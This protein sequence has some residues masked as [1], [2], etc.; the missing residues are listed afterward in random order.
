L[1]WFC[2]IGIADEGFKKSALNP[3]YQG[4]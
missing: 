4:H 2:R 1:S 3:Q